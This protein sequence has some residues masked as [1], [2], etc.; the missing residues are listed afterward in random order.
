MPHEAALDMSRNV[1]CQNSQG[2]DGA[3]LLVQQFEPELN[4]SRRVLLGA[5]N[6]E[7]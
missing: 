4:G 2:I 5:Y 7:R 6:S 1:I 3:R